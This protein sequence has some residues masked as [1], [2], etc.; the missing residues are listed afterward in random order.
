MSQIEKDKY[1]TAYML[2]LKK[3]YKSTYVQNRNRATDIDNKVTGTKGESGRRGKNWETGIDICI[4]LYMRQIT[5]KNLLYSTGNSTQ[6][7]VM[8]YMGITFKKE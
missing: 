6:Y 4:L 1:D 7:S 8:I 3:C 5:N 2:N